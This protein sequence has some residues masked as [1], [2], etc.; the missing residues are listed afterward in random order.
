MREDWSS[1]TDSKR[2][3]LFPIVLV[4]YD[5]KWKDAYRAEKT[6]LQ[7]VFGETINRISHIGSTA[8]PGLVAKPTIDIL[9]E[10]VEG[11]DLQPVTDTLLHE[12]YV[13]NAGIDDIITYIKGYTPRGFE[14]QT[15]HIHVRNSGDWGELY[16]RD[17]LLAHPETATQ[18]A[19]LKL[20]LQGPYRHDRD[21]YTQAKGTFICRYTG[22]ARAEFS[23]RYSVGQ[24]K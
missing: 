8:V 24:P 16:F 14:G 4:E 9:L 20:R 5:A 3:E 21:G 22:L 13:V 2:A 10:V 23:G 12:G 7:T 17:Y 19:A 6:Y 15:A 11:I 1:V 18:Y